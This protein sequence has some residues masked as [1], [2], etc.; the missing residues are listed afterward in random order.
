M[1]NVKSHFSKS[2]ERRSFGERG[3]YHWVVKG[4]SSFGVRGYNQGSGY[5]VDIDQIKR[6]IA[7]YNKLF[8]DYTSD[9]KCF[10]MMQH[11]LLFREVFSFHF[12]FLHAEC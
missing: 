4:V 1:I 5:I 8:Q 10:S 2:H 12:V 6:D 3:N 7:C 11:A 9:K